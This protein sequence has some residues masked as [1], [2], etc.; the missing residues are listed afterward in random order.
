MFQ[1]IKQLRRPVAGIAL[2]SGL[3]VGGMLGVGASPASAA[4]ILPTTTSVVASP[5]SS[6]INPIPFGKLVTLT[7]TVGPLDLL[8]TPSGSVTFSIVSNGYT[9]PLASPKLSSC[10]ILLSKCTASAS[11]ELPSGTWVV[12]G[13]YSGDL[14]SATSSGATTVVVAPEPTSPLFN[15]EQQ[16]CVNDPCYNEYFPDPETSNTGSSIQFQGT[17]TDYDFSVDDGFSNPSLTCDNLPG[18]PDAVWNVTAVDPSGQQKEVAYTV[19]GTP[20]QTLEDQWGDDIFNTLSPDN[21]NE[22]DCYGSATEFLTA[23]GTPAPLVNGLFQGLLPFC[24]GFD[25]S[26]QA[27]NPPCVWYTDFGATESGTFYTINLQVS[28]PDPQR[29]GSRTPVPT[30]SSRCDNGPGSRWAHCHVC[31]LLMAMAAL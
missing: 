28:A 10:I 11:V 6:A 12:T 31:A 13:S 2:A 14:L 9:V 20:A 16:T 26:G 15:E 27:P 25:D 18:V 23:A 30:K 29:R 8:I 3:V 4:G 17:F 19:Y 21:S 1:R 7:A 24:A 5:A 22:A